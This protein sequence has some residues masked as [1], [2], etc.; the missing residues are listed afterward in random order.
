MKTHLKKPWSLMS[1]T[2]EWTQLFDHIFFQ[3]TL[4]PFLLQKN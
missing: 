3:I 4:V 1:K 2:L